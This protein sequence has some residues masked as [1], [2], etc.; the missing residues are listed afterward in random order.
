[1]ASSLGAQP[2]STGAPGPYGF[3]TTCVACHATHPLN[4]DAVG[5]VALE[6]LPERYEP[7]RRYR[8][9]V[10]VSHA[11][12][13][14]HRFGFQLTALASASLDPAGELVVTEPDRTQL[15]QALASDRQYLGHTLEGTAPDAAG[16]ARWSFEWLAPPSS[17]GEV[18]FFAAANA[19]DEDGSKEG[20]RVYSPSPRPLAT[21]A[22]PPVRRE[23]P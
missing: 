13:A 3:E 19:V 18:A 8:L 20:D 1:M 2:G 11:D 10:T 22:G 16:A 15:M 17:V 9:H 21:L 7:G 5:R 4:P 14:L 23:R 6:G 12:P